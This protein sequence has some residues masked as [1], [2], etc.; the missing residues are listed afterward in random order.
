MDKD[1]IFKDAIADPA[2]QAP[3]SFMRYS[4]S[5]QTIIIGTKNGIIGTLPIPAEKID[6]E[7]EEEQT[8]HVKITIQVP[9]QMYGKYHT[10]GVNSIASLGN[11]TQIASIA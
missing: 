7:D 6:D 10:A 9:F 3:A 4:R 11:S 1:Y 5:H 2:S 8:E